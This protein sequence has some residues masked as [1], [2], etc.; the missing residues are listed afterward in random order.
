MKVNEYNFT[1]HQH[2]DAGAFQIYHRGA[3]A[4]DS[5]LYSGS[6]GQ[7]GSP[8]CRN[9][10]WRTIAHNTLLVYAPD[11]D[12]GKRGY[13][14]DGGQR[15]PNGRREPGTLDALLKGGYRTGKV[16][17]HGFGPDPRKPDFT[18]L[19]GDITQAYSDKVKQ[20]VRSFVFL[21]LHNR[22]VPG[23]LIVF[24][25]VVA[26]DPAYRKYWLLHTLEKPQLDGSKAIVD[27]TQ[28]AATGRLALDVLLPRAENSQA[29]LV[30]GPGKEF[31][32]FGKNYANDVDPQRL[33][34]GSMEPGA[35][36]IEVS[37]AEPRA[38]D[39]L[40]NVMQMTDR[41]AGE[42]LPV[43]RL[44]TSDRVGCLIEDH[45]AKWVVLFERDAE[46]SAD[47]VQV[48]V[49]GTGACRLLICHLQPGNWHVRR[50]GHDKTTQIDVPV[51]SQAAWLE[52]PNGRWSLERQGEDEN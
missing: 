27:R 15:L 42:I 18:L 1:N 21:H 19:E 14:N 16:M 9:Y 2:L 41:T 13:G 3:L 22:R 52:G 28:Y 4:I 35:W 17:A 25:R 29:R 8:H 32:V 43:Q 12:F 10:Y 5:G 38:E 40:L 36:R 26:T 34:H 31:S 51:D 30:G 49:P 44:E 23:A 50:P 7:Y 11:E 39:L 45:A 24:D 6:S 48:D 33:A 47:P 37:P 46:P 20:V